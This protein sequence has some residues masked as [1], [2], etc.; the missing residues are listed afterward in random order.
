MSTG[1]SKHSYTSIAASAALAVEGAIRM[2]EGQK[3]IVSLCRPPGHHC[4]TKMAGGYCYLNNAVIAVEAINR[5]HK[6]A[7]K[8][9]NQPLN[10]V[11]APKI[12]ILDIDFHHGNGTQDYFYESADVQYVSIHGEDEYPY[13]SGNSREVGRGAGEGFNFNHP[14]P[15][16]SSA[17]EYIRTL[18]Y[19]TENIR[20]FEAAYLIVSLGFDTF[21]LDPLGSFKL[22]TADYERIGYAIRRKLGMPCVIL[23]EGGYVVKD[24]GA[25]LVAFLKGWEGAETDALVV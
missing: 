5:L 7:Y 18:N 16:H 4:D 13:Y 1:I 10:D 20:D 23:L 21:H 11:P 3:S 24:L 6:A 19:A 9:E 12:A 22:E 25:N 17:I 14:L 15:T 2:F 8:R